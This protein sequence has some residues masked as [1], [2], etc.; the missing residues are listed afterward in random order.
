MPE[1]QSVS[2][3]EDDPFFNED[4]S[5]EDDDSDEEDSEEEEDDGYNTEEE[6]DIRELLREAMDAAH[7]SDWASGQK[8]AKDLDPLEQEAKQGNPFMKLLGSLRGMVWY[9]SPTETL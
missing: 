5:D 6:D 9:H 2:G 3:S 8:L 1:L 4:D 7:E